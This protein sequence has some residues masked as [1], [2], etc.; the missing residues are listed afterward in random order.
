MVK[1]TIQYHDFSV[2]NFWFS[3][4]CGII[5]HVHMTYSVE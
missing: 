2:G 5:V 1:L 4:R 3:S